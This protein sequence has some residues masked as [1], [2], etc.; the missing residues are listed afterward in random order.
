[1]ARDLTR[2]VVA[3]PNQASRV[4][5]VGGAH[6]VRMKNLFIMRFLRRNNDG[7]DDWRNGLS[8]FVKSIER[9]SVQPQ[10]E[11]VNQYNKKRVVHTGIKY[12]PISCSL[13]DTA[14]GAAMMMWSQYASYYFGDYRQD[15]NAYKD[16]IINESMLGN[17][18]EGYGYTIGKTN[19]SE[20]DGIN[21]QFFF[22]MVEV[23]QV[24]GGE[25]T[26]YQLLNPKITNFT[27]DE[28]D[29]EQNAAS[30]INVTLQF[31]G[32]YHENG[33]KPLSIRENDF[34]V[35][36]FGAE[37]SGE[38]FDPDGSKGRET[39]FTSTTGQ[40]NQDS[41]KTNYL[42]KPTFESVLPV[43]TGEATTSVGGALSKFGSFDFGNFKS[44]T[45]GL[46]TE[47][48]SLIGMRDATQAALGSNLSSLPDVAAGVQYAAFASGT[49]PLDQA[50]STTNK[51]LASY[52]STPFYAFEVMGDGDL[53]APAAVDAT[54]TAPGKVEDMGLSLSP[55]TIAAVNSRSDGRSQIG[56]RSG[57][58]TKPVSYLREP[59]PAVQLTPDLVFGRVRVGIN[60]VHTIFGTT[61]PPIIIS[62]LTPVITVEASIF[63][64]GS[65][66]GT[67]NK[68]ITIVPSITASTT[69]AASSASSIVISA[70]ARGIAPTRGSVNKPIIFASNM[71]GQTKV[72][73]SITR[74]ITVSSNIRA[75]ISL[76]SGTINKAIPFAS[77]ITGV[78]L[79]AGLV[80][81]PITVSTAASGFL[82]VDATLD[83]SIIISAQAVGSYYDGQSGTI[84]Q[85]ITISSNIRARNVA[86]FIN[87][88]LPITMTAIGGMTPAAFVNKSITVSSNITGYQVAGDIAGTVVVSSDTFGFHL[89]GN[90]DGTVVVASDAI[91]YLDPTGFI[92]DPNFGFTTQIDGLQLFGT[93]DSTII[94]PIEMSGFILTQ[95]HY[96]SG[97]MKNTA[98]DTLELSGDASDDGDDWLNHTGDN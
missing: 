92:L 38:S 4:F 37:F 21:S 52:G 2:A 18:A 24:W 19:P 62:T 56:Y 46:P 98:Q 39:S 42:K 47:V 17:S 80:N 70:I 28:L 57:S 95:Q 97:D 30:M 26:S 35:G 94:I 1:M 3:S 31:E 8:F 54:V 72:S 20:P 63:G 85:Q 53:V 36:I 81:R 23:Y 10:V 73:G 27:P 50:S 69:L 93:Q 44:L 12:N 82:S 11:E 66:G 33:G 6:P 49:S 61:T 64:Q 55:L 40:P 48:S 22:D 86:A 77:T 5:G 68:N 51:I 15:P 84:A 58:I 65:V 41:N 67:L 25:Y 13:Y 90:G 89:F 14:D 96:L 59:R 45:G 71:R 78:G 76:R 60:V 29:Y 87:R 83:K 7:G 88:P 75:N 9:P 16:D 43:D 74:S 34:L 32:I 91:A 79:V